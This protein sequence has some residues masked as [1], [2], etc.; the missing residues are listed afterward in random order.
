MV[1]IMMFYFF[2]FVF[3]MNFLWGK[4]DVEW[5]LLHFTTFLFLSRFKTQLGDWRIKWL[6][7]MKFSDVDWATQ[8]KFHINSDFCVNLVLNNSGCFIFLNFVRYWLLANFV[9]VIVKATSESSIW[10]VTRFFHLNKFYIFIELAFK[11]AW[12]SNMWMFLKL[13]Q[14]FFFIIIIC[15]KIFIKL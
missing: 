6:K 7:W 1:S 10:K 4:V 8:S 3:I 14:F 13:V 11:L 15:N 2:I 9:M 5:V 12:F